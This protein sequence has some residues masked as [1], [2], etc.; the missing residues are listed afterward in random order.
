S[1]ALVRKGATPETKLPC[2]DTLN[3]GGRV[4]GNYTDYPKDRLGDIPLRTALAFS[5]NTAFI[6]QHRTVSQDDLIAAA[7]SLGMGEDLGLDFTGFLGSV[8]PTEDTVEHA[9]S[10]SGQGRIEASPLAMALVTASVMKGET[11]RP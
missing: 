7:Q 1:L 9:A 3:V 6:S 5:C 8:P 2:T 11:V 4:F 10:F